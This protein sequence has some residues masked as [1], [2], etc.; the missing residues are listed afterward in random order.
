MMWRCITWDEPGYA[1]RIDGRMD[2]D[3]YLTILKEELQQ[4]LEFY[5]LDLFNIIFQQDNDPKHTYKK[6]QE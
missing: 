5:S 2:G 6:V 3:L 1:T 4:S